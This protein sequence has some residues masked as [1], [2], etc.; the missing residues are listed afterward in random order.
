MTA[1]DLDTRPSTETE[2]P[3]RRRRSW[4]LVA[5]AFVVAIAVTAFA[6]N[7]WSSGDDSAAP[8]TDST[9]DPVTKKAVDDAVTKALA[10]N[11]LPVAQIY[12]RVAPS[13]VEIDVT[14][15][16]GTSTTVPGDD[17][18]GLGTGLVVNQDGSILT[19]NHVVDGATKID[20]VF[21]DGTHS[22]ATVASSDPVQDI[23]VLTPQTLPSIVVPAVLGAVG[24]V[25]DP[26]VAVGNPL[27][28]DG[29]TT[30][31]V[32]SGLDRSI[33]GE[34]GQQ[35]TGLIQF[36]AAVNPGSSGGP[37]LDAKGETVGIVVALANPSKDGYFIGI[38]FA[39][40]IGTAVAGGGG[41]QPPK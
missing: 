22:S 36:D 5:A 25:G 11:G 2:P 33:N 6:A 35:R 28:L 38:G 15:P 31:G 41:N 9:I 1:S 4:W 26:V 14:K 39:V 13:L 7:R 23:A 17:G 29:T 32:V 16:P 8:T 30:S 37:L 20:V 18:S 10:A 40:P 12:Q 21:A 24:A 19:A 34:D 3:P 27:G